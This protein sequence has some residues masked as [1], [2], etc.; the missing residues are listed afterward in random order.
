MKQLV[1]VVHS[2]V[3]PVYAFLSLVQYCCGAHSILYF[4]AICSHFAACRYNPSSKVYTS[5][6][7]RNCLQYT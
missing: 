7:D 4:G 5:V 3:R 2:D 1:G 6:A